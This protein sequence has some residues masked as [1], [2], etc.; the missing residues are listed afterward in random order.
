MNGLL[1][2]N[3]PATRDLIKTMVGDA[4]AESLRGQRLL[5]SA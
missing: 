2:T 5:S 1:G 3:D 4:M